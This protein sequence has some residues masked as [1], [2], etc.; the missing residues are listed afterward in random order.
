L[1]CPAA[2]LHV[3]L[4][5]SYADRWVETVPES[6]QVVVRCRDGLTIRI[7]YED[8]TGAVEEPLPNIAEHGYCLI[9]SP[10][11]ADGRVEV[12][13]RDPWLRAVLTGT[14]QRA[15]GVEFF[16]VDDESYPETRTLNR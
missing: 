16:G 11:V 14:N 9:V 15:D 6:D 7:P 10:R 4:G 2:G 13:R 8:L 3:E 5:K 12:S 1:R